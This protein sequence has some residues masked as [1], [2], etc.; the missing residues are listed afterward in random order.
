L[1][2]PSAGTKKKVGVE[3]IPS[4]PFVHETL[5]DLSAGAFFLYQAAYF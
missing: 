1:R 4:D 5:R 2:W 3:L